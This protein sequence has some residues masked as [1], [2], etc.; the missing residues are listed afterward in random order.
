MLN[1]H[2]I[3]VLSDN[4]IYLLHEPDSNKTAVVD[5]ASADPVLEKLNTLG[6]SLDYI[7][8][9]HHHSDHVGGNLKLKQATNCQIIA[10]KTDAS[11]I[12]GLD[13]GLK[14][15]DEFQLGLE[16]AYI[17]AADG[18]TLGHI[19]FW[20]KQAEA[21]FCGDTIF[22]MGCGRL[23]EGSAEQ[24]WQ[25]L[26]KII[27]LPYRTQI[28]CAHEYTETNARFALTIEP[29]N[30]DLKARVQQVKQQRAQGQTTVPFSL[31]EELATNPFLRAHSC[32][33]FAA[34]RRQK[35]IFV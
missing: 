7:F 13:I 8:N 24:M 12:P 9:T 11:R 21:L 25:S 18:H 29:Q 31:A 20:F 30:A 16:T 2:Q 22:A 35:D 28:Y 6:L 5:P 27:E 4:Y 34:I 23:F 26:N 17:M 3:P 14:E 1:I 10:S 32:E 19:L 33:E 15:G